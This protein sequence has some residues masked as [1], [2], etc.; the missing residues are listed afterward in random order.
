MRKSKLYR[1]QREF[2][3]LFWLA[4]IISYIFAVL[5]ADVAPSIPELSD[6]AQHVFAFVVLGLFL[7]LGYNINYWY[8]LIVLVAYGV[9]IEFSQLFSINRFADINDV[10]AD[11]IGT[12]IGLKLYKY[13]RKVM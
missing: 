9:F 6:K 11:T 8:A 4:I 12:F 7:R 1:Y 2:K 13:L 10:L 3:I 5:P